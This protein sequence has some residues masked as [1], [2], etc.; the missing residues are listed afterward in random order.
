MLPSNINELISLAAF[1]ATTTPQ[2]FLTEAQANYPGLRCIVIQPVS[3]IRVGDGNIS[4]SRG[5]KVP[6][7]ATLIWD[8]RRGNPYFVTTSGTSVLDLAL[9][10]E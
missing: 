1:T 10:V 5:V 9:G 3:D 4:T 6:G 8:K 7:G 2:Q